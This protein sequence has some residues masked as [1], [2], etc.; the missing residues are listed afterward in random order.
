METTLLKAC[1]VLVPS[2]AVPSILQLGMA[3]HILEGKKQRLGKAKWPA[4]GPLAMCV[5]AGWVLQMPALSQGLCV[6]P[7][8]HR[9]RSQLHFTVEGSEEGAVAG[10]VCT[11]CGEKIQGSTQNKVGWDCPFKS[12]LTLKF[13]SRVR[14][15]WYVI[16]V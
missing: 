14:W 3:F 4:W 9:G 16:C 13:H 2:C 11:G 12:F 6:P 1:F 7:L 15:A 5:R 8:C 10:M